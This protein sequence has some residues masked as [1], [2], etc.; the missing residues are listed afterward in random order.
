[1]P[2]IDE[3]RR[4]KELGYNGKRKY[5]W[6]ACEKCGKE[7]WVRT[8]KG[9]PLNIKCRSCAHKGYIASGETRAKM[10]VVRRGEKHPNWKGGRRR[11]IKGYIAISL[12]PDDFFYPMVKK[13]G[14]V[15]EHRLVVA[16][17]LSRCLLPW[18]VV[19][20]KDGIKD[21]NT[22]D[23]L[24]LLPNQGKHNTI[25]NVRIRVLERRVTILEAENV[26]LQK[27]LAMFAEKGDSC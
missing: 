24:I 14:Y 12:Q 19:H 2:K 10:S 16:K 7:R 9:E 23:N 6:H 5:I 21:H 27:N 22:D 8:K 17:R 1:M 3:I 25:L 4:A 13:D 26:I 15:M 20:H 18:E 11:D